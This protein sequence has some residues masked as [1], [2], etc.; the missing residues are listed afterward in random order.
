MATIDFSKA[1]NSQ[2]HNIII[3]KLSDMGVPGWL[4]N[5]VMGYLEEDPSEDFLVHYYSWY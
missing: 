4:I 1:Y 5:L 3:T 2:S